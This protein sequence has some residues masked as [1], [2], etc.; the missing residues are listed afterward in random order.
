[1]KYFKYLFI[2]IFLFGFISVFASTHTYTRTESDLLVP[3]DVV[4]DDS[5]RSIIMKTPAVNTNE[6]IYDFADLFTSK[7]ETLLYQQLEKYVSYSGIDAVVVTV[8]DLGDFTIESYT[9]SF[10]DYNAFLEDGMIL[11]F[12]KEQDKMNAYVGRKGEEDSKVYTIYTNS[13][14]NQILKVVREDIAKKDYNGATDNYIQTLFGFYNMDQN[15]D[16]R[17]GEDGKFKGRIW[18]EIG[19]ITF[20]ITFIAVAFLI[21][22]IMDNNYL[23]YKNDLENKINKSDSVMQKEEE[24]YIDSIL[25]K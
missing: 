6:K 25:S 19:I 8:R 14:I 13:R 21:R 1:M 2:V 5:N 3:D 23:K 7:Q 10:Y 18:I 9:N 17:V 20:S 12:Y 22:K 16:Y 4:V 11:V 24:N 15:G